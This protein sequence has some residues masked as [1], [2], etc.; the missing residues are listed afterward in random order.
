MDWL[1]NWLDRQM[2]SAVDLSALRELPVRKRIATLVRARFEALGFHQEAMRRSALT[3]SLPQNLTGSARGLW[4]SADRI[5]E[6]AR[7]PEQA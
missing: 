3:R 2:E 4:R 6:L 5:W 1:D 7:F